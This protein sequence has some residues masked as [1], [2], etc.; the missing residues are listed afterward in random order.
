[1]GD[2]LA[3]FPLGAFFVVAVV[4][5][6]GGPGADDADED[7]PVAGGEFEAREAG[8]ACKGIILLDCL[9][10]FKIRSFMSVAHPL[11]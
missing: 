3:P 6:G 4:E 11:L 7:E 9:G 10:Y 5:E 8:E 1:M 2:Q